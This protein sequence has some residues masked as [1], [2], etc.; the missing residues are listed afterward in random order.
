MP[1]DP[2]APLIV[3]NLLLL[4]LSGVLNIVARRKL[5]ELLPYF[6]EHHPDE[7]EQMKPV[8]P[9]GALG[10]PRP[11]WKVYQFACHHAPLDDEVAE[12]LL[13]DYARFARRST[14]AILICFVLTFGFACC[15]ALVISWL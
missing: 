3:G 7:Y 9:F 15:L 5:I 8:R 11:T 4:G 13:A 14:V 2:F 12:H 10:P 6:Q 1:L